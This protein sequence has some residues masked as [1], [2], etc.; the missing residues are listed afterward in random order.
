MYFVAVVF[1]LVC[2]TKHQVSL[3]SITNENDSL[4]QLVLMD[5]GICGWCKCIWECATLQKRT[6]FVFFLIL[7]SS[8]KMSYLHLISENN[9]HTLYMPIL[10]PATSCICNYINKFLLKRL[11]LRSTTECLKALFENKKTQQMIQIAIF[12]VI[13]FMMFRNKFRGIC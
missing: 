3:Q 5:Q 1:Q 9:K 11:L 2:A 12:P 4:K 8:V 7:L 6:H 10:S 13:Y